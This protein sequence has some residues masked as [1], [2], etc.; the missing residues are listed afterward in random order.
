[1][2]PSLFVLCY[3]LMNFESV[4]GF[5]GFCVVHTM[6]ALFLDASSSH[7]KMDDH[8]WTV[9][10]KKRVKVTKPDEIY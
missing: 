4:D 3:C 10:R 1:M 5:A 2:R 8:F 6:L 7:A 9:C